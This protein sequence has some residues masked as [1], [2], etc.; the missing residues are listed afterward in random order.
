MGITVTVRGYS[1]TTQP[2]LLLV[3]EA[4]RQAKVTE[5]ELRRHIRKV[6]PI[7]SVYLYLDLI[8]V[9]AA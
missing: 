4:I 8:L 9:A 7:L 5:P 6:I 1:T 3:L 2:L